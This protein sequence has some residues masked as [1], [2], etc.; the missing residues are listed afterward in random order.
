MNAWPKRN[1]YTL[2]GR[3]RR[4]GVSRF[5]LLAIFTIL[6]IVLVGT[7][8]CAGMQRESRDTEIGWQVLHAIDTAQTV[9]IARSPTCL[10]EANALAAILY[11]T[12]N[13]S[14]KR[15][16]WT[17]A[18]GAVLHWQVAGWVD[19]RGPEWL[20]NTYVNV[21]LIGTGLA[22]GNNMVRGVRPFSK[23]TCP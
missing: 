21:S 20:R 18:A 15:V 17:N 4:R 2:R 22:V 8:G 14:V 16:L 1:R 11:G 6:V 19:R 13:P 9:T 12:R 5:E 7:S 23:A 3:L 10:H